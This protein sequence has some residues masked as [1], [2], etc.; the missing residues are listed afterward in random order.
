M[1]SYREELVVQEVDPNSTK[2][3]GNGFPDYTL[4]KLTS[5]LSLHFAL[6]PS[7]RQIT[8]RIRR[9]HLLSALVQLMLERQEQVL[10]L[11]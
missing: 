9:Q 3:M 7:L 11:P 4:A 8:N 6:D 5:G 1:A 10:C 2:Q